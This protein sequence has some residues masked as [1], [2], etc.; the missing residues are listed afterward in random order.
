[1]VLPSSCVDT[2]NQRLRPLRHAVAGFLFS[3]VAGVSSVVVRFSV[4]S[5]VACDGTLMLIVGP[6]IEPMPSDGMSGASSMSFANASSSFVLMAL[7]SF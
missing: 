5:A 2:G 6:G 3:V 4:G 7:A 1:V